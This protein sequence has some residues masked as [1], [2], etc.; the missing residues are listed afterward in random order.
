MT[1]TADV[2]VIGG[3]INGCC[4]SYYLAKRGVK[5]IVLVEKGH[6]ASGPTGV[7][8]GVV[9]QHYTHETLAAMARDSVKIWQN[10]AEDIGGDAGFVQCGVVFFAPEREAE[11]LREAVAMHQRIGI[12][13]KLLSI[14][15]LKSLE[16][17]LQ[18]E[19]IALG[20]YESDGGYA[21]PAAAAS[22][23]GAAAEREGVE[24]LRK[25]E[26]VG[27]NVEAGRIKGIVTS[28]GPIATDTVVNVAG[29]W[30]AR[31]A[32]MA[33]VNIPLRASRH[34]VVMLHRPARWSRP[35][36][37]WGDLVTGWY[38]KPEGKTGMV[39]GSLADI[40]EGADPDD[41]ARTPTAAETEAYSGAIVKRFP[42]MEEGT[43]H[44]GWAGIYDVTPD[45]QPVIDRIGDVEGFSCA[46]G[47]SGHGFKIAPAV[48][49]VMAQLVLDGRCE[50]Y[51]IELFRYA[52]LKEHQTSRGAYEFGIIG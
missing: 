26:V 19:D 9:R 22:S 40:D 34:A 21:D 38:F 3:G 27:L 15:E 16:P 44:G 37:V 8:S 5:K 43:L 51:D 4:T 41:Y 18:L 25:T 12:R 42:V 14:A 35:T 7:S 29:P 52:R 23:F 47:F 45:W 49:K 33:G 11:A 32:A 28:A 39:V 30:G 50:S 13:E 36:P 31:V 10:F 46:V 17:E 6:I 48:G 2:V 1:K 20:A 24:V